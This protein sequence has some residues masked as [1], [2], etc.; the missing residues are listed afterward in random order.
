VRPSPWPFEAPPQVDINLQSYTIYMFPVF[1]LLSFWLHFLLEIQ[2]FENVGV[3]LPQEEVITIFQHFFY[4]MWTYFQ[5]SKLIMPYWKCSRNLSI[6]VK[7]LCSQRRRCGVIGRWRRSR[8]ISKY[9]DLSHALI[10]IPVVIETLCVRGS[11]NRSGDG[12]RSSPCRGFRGPLIYFI[13][14]ATCGH[15]REHSEKKCSVCAGNVCFG[16]DIRI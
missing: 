15:S 3:V 13:F 6:I 10:F 7:E 9:I 4:L 5:K 11:G 14:E 1:I 12:T 2:L 8:K 16:G